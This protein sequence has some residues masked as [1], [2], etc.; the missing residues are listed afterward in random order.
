MK[1][2]AVEWLIDWMGKNQYYIGNDLLQAVQEAKEIEKEQINKACYDGYYQENLYDV[3]KYYNDTYSSGSVGSSNNTVPSI[4]EE[5][6]KERGKIR[7]NTLN[8]KHVVTLGC[9]NK[10]P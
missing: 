2:T 3:R 8:K 5:G 4:V 7:I 1:Q 9:I 10:T 6:G